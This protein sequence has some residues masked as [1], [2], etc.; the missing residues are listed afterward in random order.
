MPEKIK[1]CY[2]EEIRHAKSKQLTLH[3][4]IS[5]GNGECVNKQKTPTKDHGN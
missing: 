4:E 5:S 2:P 1:D 3:N